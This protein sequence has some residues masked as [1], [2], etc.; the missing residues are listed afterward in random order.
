MARGDF[1]RD[2]AG[3][4]AVE[5]ALVMPLF[6]TLVFGVF[7]YGWAL[8]CGAE[9]RYAVQRASRILIA[10]PDATVVDLRA[11]VETRLNGA[12]IDDVTL[13]LATETFGAST[14]V[15]RISWTYAYTVETPFLDDAVLTFDSSLLT[16]L[17]E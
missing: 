9:V 17:R 12:D 4:T 10:D 13:T 6:V 16:P 5:L 14:Q 11:A 2:V 7:N 1:R 3:A 15:A 8:Y